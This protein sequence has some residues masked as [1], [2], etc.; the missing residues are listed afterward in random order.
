M[1]MCVAT[2]VDVF[3]VIVVL[4]IPSTHAYHKMSMPNDNNN[5]WNMYGNTFDPMSAANT[6]TYVNN[7]DGTQYTVHS[8]HMYDNTN[9]NL[10]IQ[11][12]VLVYI[13]KL[14]I[15]SSVSTESCVYHCFLSRSYHSFI[16]PFQCIY[17]NDLSEAHFESFYWIHLNKKILIPLL[18]QSINYRRYWLSSERER[19]RFS[20]DLLIG[21][22]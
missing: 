2:D 3:V 16:R 7:N 20:F 13:S 21:F 5:N 14:S 10:E 9:D 22:H 12:L 11:I 15:L 4:L 19:P 18:S 17:I 8:S 6:Y 1:V